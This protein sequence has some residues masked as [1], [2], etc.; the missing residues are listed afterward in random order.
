MSDTKARLAKLEKATRIATSGEIRARELA[1]TEFLEWA[2]SVKIGRGSIVIPQERRILIV[3]AAA[4]I[5]RLARAID[6]AGT[7]L[8]AGRDALT[9][10]KR[11]KEAA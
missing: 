1:V 3:E 4:E 2:E 10:I 11:I 6:T 7:A 8:E 9:E 5:V